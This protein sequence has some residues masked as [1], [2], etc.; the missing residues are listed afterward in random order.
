MHSQRQSGTV[1]DSYSQCGILKIHYISWRYLHWNMTTWTLGRTL[2]SQGCLLRMMENYVLIGD[3]PLQSMMLCYGI[4]SW[5]PLN[6]FGWMGMVKSCYISYSTHNSPIL[7]DPPI[8]I[9]IMMIVLDWIAEE[10]E[11]YGNWSISVANT[12]FMPQLW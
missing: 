4:C 1:R 9:E 12:I 5:R 6:N 8:F 2:R 7:C 11:K 10:K 3:S